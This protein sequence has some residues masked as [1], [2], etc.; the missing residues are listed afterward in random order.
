V[1][2]LLRNLLP[3]AQAVL[4]NR[5]LE[6]LNQ[7]FSPMYAS[8]VLCTAFRR[9]RITANFLLTLVVIGTCS[10]SAYVSLARAVLKL[11]VDRAKQIL[12][13]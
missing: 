13:V 4:C 7:R 9:R 8:L 12:L 3:L 2:K 5:I 1:T 6:L 11:V 10:P